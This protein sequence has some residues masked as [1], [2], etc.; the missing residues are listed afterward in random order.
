[1]VDQKEVAALWEQLLGSVDYETLIP[2]FPK[3]A[4]VCVEKLAEIAKADEKYDAIWKDAL[5]RLT[6]DDSPEVVFFATLASAATT[7][8]EERMR[9]ILGGMP[10][11]SLRLKEQRRCRICGCTDYNACYGGCYWVELDLCS[12]CDGRRDTD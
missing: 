8:G 11:L 2:K 1:M 10:I 4:A 7:E 12:R 9:M 3:Q 5:E 6:D